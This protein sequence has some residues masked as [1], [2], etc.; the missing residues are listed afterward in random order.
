[1]VSA[2][3]WNRSR[4]TA[5]QFLSHMRRATITSAFDEFA[6][7][8]S[9]R[10]SFRLL[11]RCM[12]FASHSCRSI[13][14][15]IIQIYVH[16]C[17]VC[18][19]VCVHCTAH[20]YTAEFTRLVIFIISINKF[21][22]AFADSFG[23]LHVWAYFRKNFFWRPTVVWY[24]LPHNGDSANEQKN[25]FILF[26]FSLKSVFVKLKWMSLHMNCL[27][28]PAYMWSVV[29]I[30]DNADCPRFHIVFKCPTTTAT[31][32][33][34]IDNYYYVWCLVNGWTVGDRESFSAITFELKRQGAVCQP[35][36]I[37]F[38]RCRPKALRRAICTHTAIAYSWIS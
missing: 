2:R 18:V 28:I 17:V 3:I 11:W 29:V 35:P 37:S 24:V 31:L 16:I 23:R 7:L 30:A 22:F 20:Q 25:G 1:M 10:S 15:R 9:R 14:H 8:F 38:K 36:P 32:C 4:A 13:R 26:V 21:S 34:L 5:K 19:C 12:S 6:T 27:P 33:I